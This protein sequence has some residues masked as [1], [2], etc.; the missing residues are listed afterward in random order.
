MKKRVNEYKNSMINIFEIKYGWSE[1]EAKKAIKSYD[2]DG[3]LK[4]CKF[5]ALHDDPEIW[6]DAIYKWA[7]DEDELL[8]M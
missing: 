4:S 7:N 5:V 2:F 1:F 8:E 3:L 6:V